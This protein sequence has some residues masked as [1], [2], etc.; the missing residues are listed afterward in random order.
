MF[1][2]GVGMPVR[3][4]D[5]STFYFMKKKKPN[6]KKVSID[7]ETLYDLY[8]IQ[9]LTMQ[10]C[11]EVLKVSA[12]II[13]KRLREFEIK[14]PQEKF[15]DV[16]KRHANQSEESLEKR[17]ATTQKKYGV[18]NISKLNKIKRKKALTTQEHLGVENP[19]QS[20][21]VKA[22][23]SDK[24]QAKYGV[25][26]SCMRKECRKYSGND[27]KP[28]QRFAQILDNFH[29]AYEREYPLENYSFDFRIGNILFEIDPTIFHNSTFSPIGEPKNK[30]YHIEKSNVAKKY[31]YHCVH[32]FDWDDEDKVVKT[33]LVSKERIYARKCEISSV[34]KSEA[35]QFLEQN[36]FQG[37]ANDQI[38]L[39]L[40]YKG[41]LVEIMTF[42]KP[43]YSKKYDYELIRLCAI[44]N[45]VGGTER[46]L[47]HFIE[48]YHPQSII[49]YC[50]LSKFDGKVYQKLGFKEMNKPEPSKHWFNIET[51]QHITDNLL[52]QRG[53]D[54]LFKT[55]FGK[56]TS[57]E[58]LMKEHGFVEVYDCG[59][60][61]FVKELGNS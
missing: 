7:K 53:F 10:E 36:H 48:I 39:G 34:T 17:R 5:R 29:I 51:K 38:R 37:Y 26:Y 24:I 9:N 13:K 46:L 57:N 52:R 55:N 33:F 4:S 31:D 50:D 58:E 14:K 59:Q 11:A 47:N 60:I 25:P 43:R 8:I 42:G 6:P 2:S 35:E 22:K 32:V 15:K 12:N 18:D 3:T 44:K 21:T 45:V 56:G 30:R 20:E 40:Y 54:Q 19:F 16:H 41:E 1:L 23:I 27:S 49:S 61:S 28:N